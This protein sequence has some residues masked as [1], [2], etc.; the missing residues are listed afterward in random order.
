MYKGRV[1]VSRPLFIH[2]IVRLLPYQEFARGSEV[3]CGERVEI[4]TVCDRFTVFISTIP[5]RR[6]TLV[7]I[8]TCGLMSDYQTLLGCINRQ[9]DIRGRC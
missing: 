8:E 9:R 2:L 6:T 1:S 7:F 5:V 3:A 4:D